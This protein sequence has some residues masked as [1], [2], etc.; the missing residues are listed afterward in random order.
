VTT[1]KTT[2]GLSPAQTV[3]PFFLDCLLR[4]DARRNVLVQPETQGERVRIEG[5]VLDG[6][7][8][9]V[10]DAVVEIWQANAQGRY[11]HPA[12]TRE[13]VALDPAF[14]GFGRSGTDVTG[15]YWFETVKPGSVPFDESRMQAP[16][17]CVMVFARGLLNHV[18]TRLYFADEPS[19]EADPILQR[20]PT[21]RRHTLVARRE[22]G[23]NG[24]VH[25][26]D[27]VLQG[28]NETAFFN[29]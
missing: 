23:N 19:N 24:P 27:I 5:R 29:V 28:P 8:E 20:V 18:A 6:D 15:S 22:M 10:P 1:L 9:S 25:R 3:G 11:R 2:P 21:D 17:I 13:A 26:F 12:D 4:E 14:M 7:G 16:H